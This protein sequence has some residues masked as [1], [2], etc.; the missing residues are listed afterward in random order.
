MTVADSK[1]VKTECTGMGGPRREAIAMVRCLVV[2][3]RRLE[4]FY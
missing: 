4:C 3:D 1:V 2:S